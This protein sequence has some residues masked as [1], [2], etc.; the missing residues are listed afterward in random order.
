MIEIRHLS[1]SFGGVPVLK[2]VNL[3]IGAGE[4]HAL[5]G[6]N[7]SGKSTIVKTLSGY[8]ERVDSGEITIREVTR[9]LP[10]R[11]ADVH[12]LGISFVHQDL[13][14]VEQMSLLDNVCLYAGYS[15]GRFGRINES[16]SRSAA[17]DAL[18]QL[19]L[20]NPP[21]TLVRDLGPTERV[22]VAVARAT[23]S[24]EK[25][26]LLV[27]DEPTAAIPIGDIA[28]IIEVVRTRRRA[29]WAVL[30]ISHRLDEVLDLADRVSIL[31]D[32]VLV[33][34]RISGELDAHELSEMIVGTNLPGQFAAAEVARKR[35]QWVPAEGAT[36]HRTLTVSDLRG[37][38][39]QG[40]NLTVAPGEI[41][42]VTGPTGCGKSELGRILAGA[43]RAISG[44][45]ALGDE[46]L[47]FTHPSKA[48]E[49]GIAYVPQDRSRLALIPKGS[50]RENIS[51]LR[52]KHVTT[53][54]RIS[55]SLES[56]NANRWIGAFG[57]VPSSQERPISS[58]SGGNQQKTVIARA[59][60][61]A[62]SVLVLDDPTA[63]VDVGARAQIQEIIHELA[64]S[65]LPIVLLSTELD[66]IV[67]L[68]DR[69]VILRRGVVSLVLKEP[70][71]SDELA[72]AVFA[73]HMVNQ[74]HD[75]SEGVASSHL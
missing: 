6:A 7:G 71:N 16:L 43:E 50:V 29:G 27:L 42:G 49:A 54:I 40:I 37:K 53:G 4:I 32:G 70:F 5:V 74:Q 21:E 1:K 52:L 18:H 59:V 69:V 65:G 47:H 25:P 30:Y 31:R 17:M 22:I 3:D 46:L 64:L 8:H 28:R 57:I 26:G 61:A 11:V 33:A 62:K 14:L 39:L 9:S 51:G 12:G 44:S 36:P 24:R 20:E 2:D 68:C 60:E 38:R 55:R 35:S 63:G 66:E 19:G 73:G 67:S 75:D 56:A 45:L 48:L 34:T 13:G 41:V 72:R 23:A 15:T 58:L 10:I